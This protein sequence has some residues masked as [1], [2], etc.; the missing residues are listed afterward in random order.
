MELVHK[1]AELSR[2][3]A[4]HQDSTKEIATTLRTPVTNTKV[5][6]VAY[7]AEVTTELESVRALNSAQHQKRIAKVENLLVESNREL[8]RER[9]SR[10]TQLAARALELITKIRA[11]GEKKEQRKEATYNDFLFPL[12]LQVVR[13]GNVRETPDIKGALMTTLNAQ[14][15]VVAHGYQGRWIK[16]TLQDDRLGWMHYSLLELPDNTELE[17]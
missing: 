7:L 1:E 5:E 17:K 16:V 10:A 15:Q 14:S 8:E 12:R 6:T 13:R 11:S 3:S 4:T 9:F 2:S